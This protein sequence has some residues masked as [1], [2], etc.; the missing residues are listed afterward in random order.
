MRSL[1][2]GS[3]GTTR[4]GL[5]PTYR[6]PTTD[7]R[8][9]TSVLSRGSLKIPALLHTP[10]SGSWRPRKTRRAVSSGGNPPP[11]AGNPPPTAASSASKRVPPYPPRG[12][13]DN[14]NQNPGPVGTQNGPLALCGYPPVCNRG[15]TEPTHAG[16]TDL[17][18]TAEPKNQ[19]TRCSLIIITRTSSPLSKTCQM[20][21][22]WV[23]VASTTVSMTLS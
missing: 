21:A 17:P 6:L 5:P 18:N 20:R 22:L 14:M 12:L 15:V 16:R 1:S 19:D 10:P 13:V 23:G 7:Y 9:P 4:L 8:L 3:L 11:T 2:V